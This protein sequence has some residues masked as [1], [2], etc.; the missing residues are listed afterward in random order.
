MSWDHL[1]TQPQYGTSQHWPYCQFS[2]C[3]GCLPPPLREVVHRPRF[4]L[5]LFRRDVPRTH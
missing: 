4:D 5:S 2:S 1:L 3:T